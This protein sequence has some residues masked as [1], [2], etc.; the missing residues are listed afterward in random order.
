MSEIL[1][2]NPRRRRKK[3][4][5]RKR[6]ARRR[7]TTA[8]KRRRNP[9]YAIRRRRAP[10]ARAARAGRRRVSRRRSN[11]APRLTARSVQANIMNAVPGAFG[12]LALDVTLGYLPLPAQFK[13]GLWGY[14]TKGI[15]AIG[16]GMLAN[17]SGMV[18]GATAAKLTEGALTVM[19]HGAMRQGMTEFA[20]G[21]PLGL[22][23][24]G[25][26]GYYGSGWNPGNPSF[27]VASPL[28]AYL[29]DISNAEVPADDYSGMN[30][31]MTGEY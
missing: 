10:R 2:V 1:L 31:Y 25:S 4:T 24:D 3:T 27:D 5:S 8:R 23:D 19:M 14:V 15:G 26:M 12:A 29:P 16:L 30:A 21:V 20:P 17:A 28:S 9:G 18:R 11:P 7:K 22:Y 13:A 6:P